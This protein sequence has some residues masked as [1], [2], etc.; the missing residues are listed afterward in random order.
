MKILKIFQILLG[1]IGLL[2]ITLII[3]KIL[4]PISTTMDEMIFIAYGLIVL[5]MIVSSMISFRIRKYEKNGNKFLIYVPLIYAFALIFFFVIHQLGYIEGY[6]ES[7]GK[8]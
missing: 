7:M 2:G 5:G 4:D 3:I 1:L 8:G 6:Y